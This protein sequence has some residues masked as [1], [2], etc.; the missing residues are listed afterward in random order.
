MS[1][2]APLI[3]GKYF[4]EFEVGMNFISPGRTVTESDI[5]NFAVVDHNVDLTG[6]IRDFFN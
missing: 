4:E 3:R 2:D 5:V 1:I 6:N